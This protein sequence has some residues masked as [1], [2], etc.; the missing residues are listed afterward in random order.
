MSFNSRSSV[1]VLQIART[2]HCINLAELEE[3]QVDHHVNERNAKLELTLH[4]IIY[5]RG[6]EWSSEK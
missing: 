4:A 1:F 6:G 3:V 5:C 2:L